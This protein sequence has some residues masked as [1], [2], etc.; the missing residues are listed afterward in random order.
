MSRGAIVSRVRFTS[1]MIAFAASRPV[2]I[3]SIF[4]TATFC[5]WVTSVLRA[6]A[7]DLSV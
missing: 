1:R 4:S 7:N 6:L 2:L 5:W 3:A